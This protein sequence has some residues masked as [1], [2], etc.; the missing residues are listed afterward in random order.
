MDGRRSGNN[1]WCLKGSGPAVLAEIDARF[2]SILSGFT[3]QK[4]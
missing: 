3:L 1:L 2:R 4:D